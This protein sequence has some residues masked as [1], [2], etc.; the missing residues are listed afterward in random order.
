MNYNDVQIRQ[1]DNALELLHERQG[2]VD[3]HELWQAIGHPKAEYMRDQLCD[4]LQLTAKRINSYMLTEEGERAYQMGFKAWLDER[5]QKKSE[6]FPVK[7]VKSES[8]KRLEKWLAW[9]GIIGGIAAGIDILL[10]L[11]K[12]L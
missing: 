8:E 4:V 12:L 5:E 3:G 6:P 9:G 11:L 10:N 2:Y 1:A 7:N